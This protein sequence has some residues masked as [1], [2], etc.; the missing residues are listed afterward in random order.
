MKNQDE[1][2][3]IWQEQM[4]QEMENSEL[5]ESQKLEIKE[6][7][8]NAKNNPEIENYTKEIEGLSL[9][10]KSQNIKDE[11]DSKFGSV[12]PKNNT[13]QNPENI[14]IN[15][16]VS[17]IYIFIFIGISTIILNVSVWSFIFSTLSIFNSFIPF[18][19][20]FS[21]SGVFQSLIL[22]LFV[23]FNYKIHTKFLKKIFGELEIK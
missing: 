22:I 7:V 16:Q 10:S 12:L 19:Y 3:K 13:N 9:N 2:D 5:T 20:R 1:I 21:N 18:D 15:F 8:K 23:Y 4:K 14:K 17:H 6:K 11:L